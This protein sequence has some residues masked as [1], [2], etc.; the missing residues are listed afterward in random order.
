MRIAQIATL[1]TTV[2]EKGSDSIETLVW[3]LSREL[4]GLGHE[5]TV[6][7]AAGSEVSAGCELVENSPGTYGSQGAPSDWHTC[8]WMHL[9]RAVEQSRRFDVIHSHNYL[10]GVPLTRLAAAPMVHTLHIMPSEDEATLL[11]MYPDACVTAISQSQ[12]QEFA[13]VAPRDVIHHGLATEQFTFRETPEDYVCYLG[14]F[15]P[16]KGPVAAI[17]AARRLG[18]RLR[19]AGPADDYFRAAVAPHVDGVNVSHV[20]TVAGPG[21]DALL[22]GARALLY[23]V[24]EG[25][26]FGL[27]IA[28]A[29]MCGTPVAAMR[30]GAVT[31]LIE[32]GVTGYTADTPE[33]FADAV[34]KCMSLD[35]G[36]VR[37]RAEARFSSRRMALGYLDVYE[38]LVAGRKAAGGAP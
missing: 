7:A 22:G 36:R 23:P 9:C 3:L 19:M 2:R 6:F 34:R 35:R 32:E 5:V 27:V 14:R 21:R 20:G 4:A 15:T 18:M 11:R 29:M 24:A 16:G 26:P 37:E 10:W 31:E 30:R 1:A 25:E 8:E 13:D 38:R 33:A 17:E 12:W 28:E